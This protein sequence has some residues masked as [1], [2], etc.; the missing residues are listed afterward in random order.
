[1][2]IGDVTQHFTTNLFVG[3]NLL[4]ADTEG[5]PVPIPLEEATL[6]LKE[7]PVWV[8]ILCNRVTP[9]LLVGIALLPVIFMRQLHELKAISYVFLGTMFL[10]LVFLVL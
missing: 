2:V 10:F 7:Q 6:F 9:I 8:Q 1:M 4:K 5:K 3:K